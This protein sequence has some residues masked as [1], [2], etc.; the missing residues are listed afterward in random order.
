MFKIPGV[1]RWT[2]ERGFRGGRESKLRRGGATKDHESSLSIAFD[3][4]A[5][6]VCHVIRK[7]STSV[8]R[9]LPFDLQGEILDEKRNPSERPIGEP[10]FDGSS[11]Q[12][13]EKLYENVP[14]ILKQFGRGS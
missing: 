9:T 7:K 11:P 12:G 1:S 4:L 10:L 5:V 8:G 6:V 14:L 13:R 2:E 3:Q